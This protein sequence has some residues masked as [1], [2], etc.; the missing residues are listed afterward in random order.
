MQGSHCVFTGGQIFKYQGNRGSIG[1]MNQGGDD[2]FSIGSLIRSCAAEKADPHSTPLSLQT[3]NFHSKVGSG[4]RSHVQTGGQQQHRTHA[5][6]PKPST[7][8]WLQTCCGALYQG[9]FWGRFGLD[10]SSTP[11]RAIHA[12][13]NRGHAWQTFSSLAK[14]SLILSC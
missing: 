1:R 6:P 11:F 8:Y 12:A 3:F 4:G 13:I 7:G 14:T 9:V 10:M 2:P 5:Q